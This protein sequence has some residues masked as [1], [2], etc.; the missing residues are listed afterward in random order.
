MSA[1]GEPGRIGPNAITRMA[2]ALEL[3]AGASSRDGLFREAGLEAYLANPP[4]SMV[5]D[6]EVARLHA[7]VFARLGLATGRTIGAE[8]G[9]RTGIYLLGHRIPKTA[10]LLLPRLPAR[11]ALRI[12]LKA[13]ERHAWTFA[14]RG[15]FAWKATPEG[16]ELKL[17]NNPV[18]RTIRADQ[19]VC[20][21]YAATFETLF[22]GLAGSSTRVEETACTAK[23]DA[24]CV[25]RVTL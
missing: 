9:R 10:R 4:T 1:P 12:L 25:F 11:L 20:D 24:A 15:L 19:P 5:P 14:G 17:L 7:V 2:E 16:F 8:A 6:D 23:G 18:S 13:V 3:L 22:R 21:Y